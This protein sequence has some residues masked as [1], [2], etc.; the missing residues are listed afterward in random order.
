M[1]YTM[2]L[3]IILAFPCILTNDLPVII[4]SFHPVSHW[5]FFGINCE[6]WERLLYKEKPK[7]LSVLGLK[8]PNI[9]FVFNLT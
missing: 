8:Q 5:K 6:P 3:Y 9:V 7:L 4:N 1:N 2:C